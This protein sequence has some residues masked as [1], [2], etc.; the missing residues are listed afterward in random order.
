VVAVDV[1]HGQL[2]P[3]LR[4]DPRVILLE[5]LN[6]R[7][8]TLSHIGGRPAIVTCDVSFISL[9]LALPRALDLAAPGARLIALIKPQFEAGREALRGSGVIRDEEL[10][11]TVCDDV[12]TWLAR[13]NP[14]RPLGIVPSPILGGDGNR[15]FLL[16]AEK[17]R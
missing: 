15:E 10:H 16:A 5:G 12:A 11:R 9:K 6:A 14:W 7:D 3:S 8:L 13:Q 1:G 2:A 17:G 4:A